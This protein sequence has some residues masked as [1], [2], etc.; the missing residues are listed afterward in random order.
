MH[1]DISADEVYAM[2]IDQQ[3]QEQLCRATG[4]LS[5][6]VDVDARA[7]G[8][9]MRVRRKLPTAGLPYAIGKIVPTGLTT[10]ETVAWGLPAA[11]GARTATLSVDFAGAPAT[12]KGTIRL[13]ADG[14]AASTVVV[15]ADFRVHLPLIGARLERIAVPIVL[16]VID[17][18]EATGRAWVAGAG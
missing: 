3:F 6:T 13:L 7:G 12:M 15:D 17:T 9:T 8:A 11:D 14:A 5:W 4:A 1:N 2:W 10:T 18:E 16:G